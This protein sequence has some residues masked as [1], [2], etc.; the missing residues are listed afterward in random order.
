MLTEVLAE[1]PESLGGAA[2]VRESTISFGSP[3]HDHSTRFGARVGLPVI[4]LTGNAFFGPV[5]TP[6]RKGEVAGRLWDA[7]V[8][9][10]E[11]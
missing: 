6:A 10:T 5:I 8:V 3:I 9:F 2:S 7:F 1:L 11:T 4:R